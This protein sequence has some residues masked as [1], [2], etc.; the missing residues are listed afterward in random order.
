MVN[1]M[2]VD[3]PQNLAL[4]NV[5]SSS[6]IMIYAL[7]AIKNGMESL[8]PEAMVKELHFNF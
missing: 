6:A 4:R 3:H 7:Q 1:N 5:V 8:S 2:M